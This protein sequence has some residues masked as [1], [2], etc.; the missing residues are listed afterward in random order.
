[1]DY[2]ARLA[3]MGV[4]LPEAPRPQANYCPYRIVGELV[5]V[6]GQLPFEGRTLHIGKLGRDI[7]VA[8]GAR[9]ARL[10]ALSLLSQLKSA[11]NGDL[12]RLEAVVKLTGFVNA[13]G[14]FTEHPVVVNGA[15]DFLV[16]VLGAA[17]V[18][19][20]SAIGVASLPLGAAVEV[21][22]IFQIKA[23]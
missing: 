13:T 8:E 11:C 15:S 3:S 10:C 19:S 16:E 23:G 20:R 4:V 18:H 6:S 12:G 1:M 5:F 9:A 14:D 17:G 7:G 22:G 21:E 2:E